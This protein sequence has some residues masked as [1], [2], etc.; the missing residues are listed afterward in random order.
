MVR[1]SVYK[2]QKQFLCST[3][4]WTEYQTSKHRITWIRL[5]IFFDWENISTL[6][7]FGIK[8]PCNQTLNIRREIST[9]MKLLNRGANHEPT[10]KDN[11]NDILQEIL[12]FS[13]MS[14]LSATSA[15]CIASF[16]AT[17][18]SSCPAME[19]SIPSRRS[20]AALFVN[21]SGWSHIFFKIWFNEKIK[22][23]KT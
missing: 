7:P 20:S 13:T 15:M 1:N 18:W 14:N 6:C 11:I 4:S 3:I 17:L 9:N 21:I 10:S 22:L 5:S 12:W 2:L 8:S 23:V 19:S 16:S